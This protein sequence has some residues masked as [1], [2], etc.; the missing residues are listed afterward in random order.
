M[1]VVVL[2]GGKA[3]PEDP[4]YPYIQDKSKAL[5]EIAGKPM[6][7]WVLDALSGA[8]S[9]LDQSFGFILYVGGGG[10][11]RPARTRRPEDLPLGTDNRL[12]ACPWVAACAG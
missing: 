2:A 1:D 10:G 9:Y 3:G 11:L 4:L 12:V 8:S 6:A 5:V 7:Q